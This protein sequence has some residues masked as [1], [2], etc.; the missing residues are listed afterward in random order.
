MNLNNEMRPGKLITNLLYASLALMVATGG[1]WL[2]LDNF[3]QQKS[4]VGLQKHPW[5]SVLINIHGFSSYLFSVLFGFIL[6]EHVA[7]VWQAKKYK[8]SGYALVGLSSVLI[9]TGAVFLFVSLPESP[10]IVTWIHVAAAFLLAVSLLSH[11]KFKR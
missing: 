5:Q 9:I 7:V 11:V 4:I 1:G 8:I 10:S 2:V 3:F 6:C